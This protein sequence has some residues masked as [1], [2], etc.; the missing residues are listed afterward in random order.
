MSDYRSPI[1]VRKI[2]LASSS[3]L[4]VAALVFSVGINLLALTAPLYML[5]VY[6]RVLASSSVETLIYLSLIA[7]AALL[8]F[9]LLEGVRSRILARIGARF[10]DV[11]STVLLRRG[12]F[13]ST[14]PAA[15]GRA[16][17]ERDVEQVRAF[18]GGAPVT[19]F[20]DF[21]W[22]FIFLFILYVLH[23]WFFYA[24]CVAAVTLLLLALASE[25]LTRGRVGKSAAAL[26]LA[27]MYASSAR[28]H[29]ELVEGMGMRSALEKRWRAAHED[30]LQGQLSA[31][32]GESKIGGIS[33]F[34]RLATQSSMLG[35]GAYLVILG[36][37][38]PGIMIAASILAARAL[39][40]IDI[41]VGS[42][43]TFVGA[44][45]AA[46]RIN[47][48]L[49]ASGERSESQE[50]PPPKGFVDVQSATLF[51]PNSPDP[52][53]NSVSF[54]IEPGQALAII[55]PSAAGKSSL[56]RMMA[57]IWRPTRGAVRLDGAMAFNWPREQIGGAVGM[58]PQEVV[59]FNGTVA[60][61]IARMKEPDARAVVA[62]A[63]KAGVHELI[64]RLP[65]GYETVVGEQGVS[66][67]G[68]QRQRI[69]LARALYGNPSLLLLDE[70]NSHLDEAGESALAACISDLLSDL[71]TVVIVAHRPSVL[72]VATH[73]ALMKEGRL[74]D[75]GPRDEVLGRLRAASQGNVG[76]PAAPAGGKSAKRAPPLK[77][78]PV[79]V[80]G[81]KG[82]DQG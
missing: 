11:A 54:K 28:R 78:H 41:A 43:K 25:L 56:L 5:Q 35:L 74:D 23:P 12:I 45:G 52:V 70:P 6:D 15:A 47:S 64:L 9:A 19:A 68:G 63:K 79:V 81:N 51:L 60:E 62:A 20:L 57:G 24:A 71:R 34:I 32:D 49:A 38:T 82:S 76:S 50:L 67:S 77:L 69:G 65:Q 29:A 66:L 1:S 53:V 26:Q 44:R 13:M 72:K 7:A 10:H 3:L 80:G 46:N 8:A 40:P 31:Q 4:V 36:D 59:L 22:I 61:N 55:G 2:I 42:W 16:P 18:I 75:F 21:P 37:A 48:F 17:S 39:A 73:V 14:V 58:L 30:A 33:K 27:Q